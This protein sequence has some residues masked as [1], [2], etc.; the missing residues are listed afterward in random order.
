MV[1]STLRNIGAVTARLGLL[2]LLLP[3]VGH[4]RAGERPDSPSVKLGR[5]ACGLAMKP[6]MNAVGKHLK[7]SEFTGQDLRGAVFT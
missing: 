5:W 1:F 4:A 3:P 7:G 2:A 6:G